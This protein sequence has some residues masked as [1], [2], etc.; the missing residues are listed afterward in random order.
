[1]ERL[2][3]LRNLP[4]GPRRETSATIGDA[5]PPVAATRE[6]SIDRAMSP[7]FFP[8]RPRHPEKFETECRAEF[9]KRSAKWRQP[10]AVP[11]YPRR[12]RSFLRWR[13]EWRTVDECELLQPRREFFP[14]ENQDA[15]KLQVFFPS[16]TPRNPTPPARRDF[17][18][19][20][21]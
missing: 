9:Y 2:I 3:I 21:R 19:D 16:R 12:A 4:R 11:K 6:V 1:M 13:A 10:L 8:A 17:W 5:V 7:R 15:P 18:G 14:T 20:D